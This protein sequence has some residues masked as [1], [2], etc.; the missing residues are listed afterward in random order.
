MA[1][2]HKHT[3]HKE[4][5]NLI[6]SC[7]FKAKLEKF[8][9]SEIGK[10]HRKESNGVVYYFNI[11]YNNWDKKFIRF[12]AIK[13]YGVNQQLTFQAYFNDDFKRVEEFIDNDWCGYDFEDLKLSVIQE[14]FK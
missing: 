2:T 8:F 14:F 11:G 6:D 12:S 10:Y 4:L 1:F 9:N 13:N 3:A 5:H 7:D